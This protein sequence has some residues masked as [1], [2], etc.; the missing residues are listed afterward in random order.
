MA[1]TTYT[2][3]S[4]VRAVLGV[5]DKE[6]KDTVLALDL[7]EQQFLL[8]MSDVDGGAG[9][10]MAQYTVIAGMDPGDRSANQSAY[11]NVLRLVATYSVGKQL[12]SPQAMFAIQ[13]LTDGKAE[14]ERFNQANLDKVRMG[15]EG[16][17]SAML[18]RLMALLA[19]LVPGAAV[20]PSPDRVM[21]VNSA[22]ALDPVTGA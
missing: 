6:L 1:L 7:W 14:F 12:L 19:L 21:V 8:E 9:A 13:R 11:Y 18:K 15:V 4:H 16:T 22:I 20:T 2:T 17:Y 5:S 3:Y 10:V